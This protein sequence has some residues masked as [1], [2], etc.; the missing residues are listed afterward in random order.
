[1]VS[2]HM[3]HSPGGQEALQNSVIQAERKPVLSGA[4]D[5]ALPYPAS[6]KHQTYE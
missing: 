2:S 3:C 4:R 6:M 5:T 1:M